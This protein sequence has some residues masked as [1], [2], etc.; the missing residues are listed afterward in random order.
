MPLTQSKFSRVK[1]LHQLIHD[2]QD[3]VKENPDCGDLMV[4]TV[5]SSSG[6]VDHLNSFHVKELNEND[7]DSEFG[8][9]YEDE[10][11]VAG[12]RVIELSVGGN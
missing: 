1:T 12:E 11:L 10:G 6:A 3:L 4:C 8:F 9:F 7:F 2:L 5:H